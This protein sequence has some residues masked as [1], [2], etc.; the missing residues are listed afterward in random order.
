MNIHTN[1]L[2][3]FKNGSDYDNNI[4]IFQLK[5]L[6]VILNTSINNISITN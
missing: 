1:Q 2:N 5:Y 6:V 4:D 3:T